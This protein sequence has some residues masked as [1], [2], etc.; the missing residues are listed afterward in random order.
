MKSYR[1]ASVIFVSELKLLP[2]VRVTLITVPHT[3]QSCGF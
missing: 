2:T 3:Y 1:S